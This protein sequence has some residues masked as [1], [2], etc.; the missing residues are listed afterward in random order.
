MGRTAAGVRAIRLKKGDEIVGMDAVTSEK[1]KDKSQKL[2][3]IM[4]N[5]YG[6]QSLVQQFKKQ[7][8]GGSGIKCAKITPKTGNVIDAQIVDAE[9]EE[10]IAI[11]RKGQVIRTTLSTVPTLGRATQGV[12]IMRMDSG[13]AVASITTL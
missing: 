9:F 13:D 12:R 6:K 8:R 2:L 3:V 10:L 1:L 5:G 4:E 11:S 7:R